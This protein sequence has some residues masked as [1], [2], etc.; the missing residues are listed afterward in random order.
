MQVDTAK[1]EGEKI[2]L[3]KLKSTKTG[4]TM[5]E[6]SDGIHESKTYDTTVYSRAQALEHYKHDVTK[7]KNGAGQQGNKYAKAYIQRGLHRNRPA[8]A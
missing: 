4:G 5:L 2:Y 7:D 3:I 8:K 6:V 1:K